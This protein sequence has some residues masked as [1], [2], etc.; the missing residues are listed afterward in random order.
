L[1]SLQLTTAAELAGADTSANADST[2]AISSEKAPPTPSPISPN[3]FT[4]GMLVKHPEYG[5]GKIIALS[6]G[7]SSRKATVAFAA[8]A[9]ERTFVLHLS[10]LRPAK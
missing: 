5:L 7:Q 4:L 10:P 2:D 3:E 9:G 1:A 8:G 6:G